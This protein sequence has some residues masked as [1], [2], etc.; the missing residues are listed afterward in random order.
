MPNR[1][2]RRRPW[3]ALGIQRPS[4]PISCNQSGGAGLWQ[5]VR[6][7]SLPVPLSLHRPGPGFVR[8]GEFCHMRCRERGEKNKSSPGGERKGR[9]AARPEPF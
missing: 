5:S 8:G 6:S 1:I 7:R 9:V 3:S 4:R 2:S